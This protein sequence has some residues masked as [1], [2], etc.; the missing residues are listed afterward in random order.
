MQNNDSEQN[1]EEPEKPAEPKVD[2]ED[3]SRFI[4]GSDKPEDPNDKY[5]PQN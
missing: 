4:P 5:M 2:K 1:T 3:D